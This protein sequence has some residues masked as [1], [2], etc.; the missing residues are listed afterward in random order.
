MSLS[1]SCEHG[2]GL[3][4]DWFAYGV[5]ED[6]VE[7]KIEA[8]RHTGAVATCA[9]D[10]DDGFNGDL[11]FVRHVDD[12]WLDRSGRPPRPVLGVG[13]RGGESEF[14]GR[15]EMLDKLIADLANVRIV[16]GQAVL[17][18][19][20][21][22]EGG[23]EHFVAPHGLSWNCRAHLG[24]DREGPHEVHAWRQSAEAQA[25]IEHRR[26]HVG[27]TNLGACRAPAPLDA[28]ACRGHEL[29]LWD[30]HE[31]IFRLGLNEV[32]AEAAGMQPG[33][34]R[35]DRNREVGKD[36]LR[37]FSA[38]VEFL[39]AVRVLRQPGDRG[40]GKFIGDA[41]IVDRLR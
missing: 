19:E 29:E 39:H 17:Q 1:G 31:L 18:R 10:R 33:R 7:E 26:I 8:G 35:G 24:G 12:A 23:G 22:V 37:P 38:N 36:R 6:V 40:Q 16:I 27:L 3:R 34:A 30:A 20:A 32:P 28:E 41:R 25:D 11:P 21:P 4:E 14:D 15:N 5:G 13:S 9:V 2:Q